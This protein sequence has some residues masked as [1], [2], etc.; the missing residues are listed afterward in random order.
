MVVIVIVCISRRSS[1][2]RNIRIGVIAVWGGGGGMGGG[3]V[4]YSACKIQPPAR[5]CNTASR[6]LFCF[7]T[8]TSKLSSIPVSSLKFSFIQLSSCHDQVSSVEL[9]SVQ[10]R[11]SS[12][13]Y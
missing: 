13:C 8:I 11:L 2:A 6:V 3:V 7:A 4:S 12:A 5:S 10:T 1:S 9:S